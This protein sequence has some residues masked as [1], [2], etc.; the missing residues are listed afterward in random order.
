MVYRGAARPIT[1]DLER[2]GGRLV[3]RLTLPQEAGMGMPLA[4]V[5]AAARHIHFE[6][7]GSD[8]HLAFDGERN[9]GAMA[10]TLAGG[11]LRATF[12]LRRKGEVPPL[13]YR[14]VSLPFEHGGVS[15]AGTLL[16]PNGP[17]PHPAVV[18][19]HG[20]HSPLREDFWAFGD[21]FAR[22]GVAA[23]LYDKRHARADP[24]ER[25]DYDFSEL[26][27][28]ALAAVAAL[29]AR[30]DLDPRGIGLWGLSEGG[31]VA[32]LATA[33]SPAVHFVVAV[34]AP[35]VTFARTARYQNLLW[36]R[37]AGFSPPEVAAAATA[38]ERVDAYTRGE[39][40]AADLQATLDR[41]WKTRW[42]PRTTLPRRV[43]TAAEIHSRHRFRDLDFDP[44]PSW[45]R[46][47]VPALVLYGEADDRMPVAESAAAVREALARAGNPDSTVRI[48][49]G[50]DHSL[51]V[52][53]SRPGGGWAW[54]RLAPGAMEEMAAWVARHAGRAAYPPSGT[55]SRPARPVAS[56]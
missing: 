27:G 37:G 21:L 40:G 52:A 20:S 19:L 24:G 4:E 9:G 33:R 12:S 56:P 16:L 23:L 51:W 50:A 25:G 29:A 7:P 2:R 49:P 42:A 22:H 43:P 47:R 30:G 26:S 34:S 32:A 13:P 5:R 17:G 35:G 10:G 44:L 14:E 6:K 3:G 41:A 46:I 55:S 39:L 31:W 15:F 36:L 1:V 28:D 18:L 8:S 45:E 54:P 38:L 48:F 11:D 53:G